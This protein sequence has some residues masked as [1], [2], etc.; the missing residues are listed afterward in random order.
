M[1]ESF[2]VAVMDYRHRSQTS[3]RPWQQPAASMR[4]GGGVR[5]V[6]LRLRGGGV[7]NRR[8]YDILGLEQGEDDENTIKKAYKKMALKWHPDR[9][10]NNKAM[11]DKKFKEVSEAYEVL[12]NKQSKEIY[13]KY[14]E[15]VLKQQMNGE[16]AEAAGAAGGMPGG[17]H[18][19]FRSVVVVVEEQAGL[20]G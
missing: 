4:G 20:G 9:N 19:S 2:E 10:P 16:G 8:Y 12:S 7:D 15:Q 17:V 13:D 14:G 5:E 1:E 3:S 11:A 6:V 18:F